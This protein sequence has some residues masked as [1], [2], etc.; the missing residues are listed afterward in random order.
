M[1]KILLIGI[2]FIGTN[3]YKLFKDKYDIMLMDIGDYPC[4]LMNGLWDLDKN[5]GYINIE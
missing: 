1:K 3:F 4:T 5:K 2:G